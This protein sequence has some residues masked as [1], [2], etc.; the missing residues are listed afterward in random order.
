MKKKDYLVCNQC[1]FCEVRFVIQLVKLGN[2]IIKNSLITLYSH[3][4]AS[5]DASICSFYAHF[6]CTSISLREGEI[7]RGKRLDQ[8]GERR[9]PLYKNFTFYLPC[10]RL[11]YC[12]VIS[13][14]HQC[15]CA[16]D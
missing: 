11:T 7:V 6:F 12:G 3:A 8:K 1:A 14:L 4:S 10:G 5:K 15:R 9:R 13:V 2:I 16:S